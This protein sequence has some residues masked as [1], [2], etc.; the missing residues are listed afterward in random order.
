MT[1][2]KNSKRVAGRNVL[3]RETK[4]K[5]KKSPAAGAAKRAGLA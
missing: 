1:T 3:R 2:H 5:I 4:M